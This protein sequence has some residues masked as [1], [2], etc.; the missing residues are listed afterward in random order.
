MCISSIVFSIF[1]LCNCLAME[2]PD[3]KVP[4]DGHRPLAVFAGVRGLNPELRPISNQQPFALR[5][6]PRPDELR[7]RHE[8]A[9]EG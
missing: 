5:P 4:A 3:E 8:A 7:A 9:R 6:A 1:F 2:S